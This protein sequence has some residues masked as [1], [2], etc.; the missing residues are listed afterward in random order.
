MVHEQYNNEDEAVIKMLDSF[1][2][3]FY[4]LYLKTISITQLRVKILEGFGQLRENGLN[5]NSEEF[6]EISLVPEKQP[7]PHFSCKMNQN[8]IYEAKILVSF[9]K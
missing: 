6:M 5:G 9:C 2:S 3:T 8:K 7:E 4:L 1:T